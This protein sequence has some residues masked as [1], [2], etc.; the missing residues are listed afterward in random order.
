MVLVNKHAKVRI[1]K[2]FSKNNLTFSLLRSLKVLLNDK[3]VTPRENKGSL[4]RN[5]R[6]HIASALRNIK[7]SFVF[8][9]LIRTFAPIY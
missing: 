4:R 3:I 6:Y 7:A 2:E 8:R 1:Y 5:R 9:S